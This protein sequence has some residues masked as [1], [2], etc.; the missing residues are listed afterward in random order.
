MTLDLRLDAARGAARPRRTGRVT[1][2]V[3]LQLEVSGLEAAIGDAVTIETVGPT[4]DGR[5]GG[6]LPAE[7]VALREGGLVCMPLGSLAGVRSGAVVTSDDRPARIRVGSCLLGRVLDGLGD[8]IDG[9][10][11]LAG[12]EEVTLAGEPPHPLRRARVDRP[13]SLGIRALDTLV[14]CGCG[15]RLGIFA[16]SGVGKSS[17]LSMIVRGTEAPVTVL[18]LVGE[19]GREV[20]EFI[21]HDLGPEGLARAVV[22]VA[23]SDEPALVRLRA[24]FTATRIAEWFRDQGNDVVLMMDSVTRF[25]MAASRPA[26]HPRRAA[27]HRRCSACCP[28][29]SSGPVPASAAA[30]PGCTPCWSTA[31][32]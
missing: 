15:Q 19:R 11:P 28:S 31:T 5:A 7:V 16:G 1:S 30:S 23:T 20:R 6:G 10:A 13:L 25:A 12:Y 17:V 22:V 4:G 2:V 32:T 3:G 29:S 21:E 8:P 26:N 27:T 9:G 14:P 24:A 18:A